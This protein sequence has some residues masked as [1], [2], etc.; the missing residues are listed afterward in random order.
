M[1]RSLRTEASLNDRFSAALCADQPLWALREVAR[2]LLA[3]SYDRDALIEKLTAYALEL[4]A[5][6]REDDEDIVFDV[7]D[8]LTGWCSAEMKL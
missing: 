3:Q 7:L 4:R 1:S 5:A 2:G 6:D 8:F